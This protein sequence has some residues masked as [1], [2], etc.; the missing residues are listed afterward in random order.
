MISE[1]LKKTILMELQLKDF[2]FK[3]ETHAYL[4]P[5]WDSLTHINVILAIEKEYGV[6]FTTTELLRL[7]NIGDLQVLINTKCPEDS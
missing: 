5:G 3:D 6:R 1:R 4:V 2:N 7:K